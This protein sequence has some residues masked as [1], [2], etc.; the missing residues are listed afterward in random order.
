[1]TA[2]WLHFM[3]RLSYS[4][5]LGAA[6]AYGGH[7]AHIGIPEHRPYVEQVRLDE[8]HHRDALRAIMDDRGIRPWVLLEWLFFAF[9]SCVAFGCRFWGDWA[10]ATGAGMFEINGVSEYNRLESLARSLG[11]AALAERFVEMAA[12]EQA[13]R[14]LFREMSRG[15]EARLLAFQAVPERASLE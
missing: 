13:H 15:R 7:S 10:S 4:S 12:Q 8:L 2:F 3:L 5:E 1:M 9:G 6:T 14:D 11:D